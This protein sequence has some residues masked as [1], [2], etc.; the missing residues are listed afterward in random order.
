M[1][2]RRQ[3]PRQAET[4]IY[5]LS[6]DFNLSSQVFVWFQHRHSSFCCASLYS[7]SQMLIFF[8]FRDGR[9]DPLPAKRLQLA[10]LQWPQYLRGVPV[11]QIRL[12]VCHDD[13][14]LAPRCNLA[15]SASAPPLRNALDLPRCS[16]RAVAPAL[17]PGA[18]AGSWQGN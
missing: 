4:S 10:L 17:D 14:L 3:Y 6:S 1:L 13:V 15:G 9:Q 18:P 11:N 12:Y 8:F 7:A 2:G 5:L 16:Q